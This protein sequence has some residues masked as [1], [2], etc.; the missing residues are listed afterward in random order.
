MRRFLLLSALL[1]LLLIALALDAGLAWRS[2]ARP[3]P[4]PV[5][6][7][8]GELM[9]NLDLAGLTPQQAADILAWVAEDGFGWVRLRVPWNEIEP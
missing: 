7:G 3:W 4:V 5:V 1:A 9:A 2:G 8:H 6:A